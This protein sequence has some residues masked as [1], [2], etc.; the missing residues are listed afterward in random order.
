MS[1]QDV[2]CMHC[3]AITEECT[4]SSFY[5]YLL[6]PYVLCRLLTFDNPGSGTQDSMKERA[7]LPLARGKASAIR[8]AP[9]A[10]PATLA[11]WPDRGA[12]LPLRHREDL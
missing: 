8:Q 1:E 6:Q 12:G 2:V 7:I 3:T 4:L 9:N 5:L 11:R 10:Q